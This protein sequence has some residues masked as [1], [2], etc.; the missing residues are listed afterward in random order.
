[1]NSRRACV[2]L[3]TLGK[4]ISRAGY[5]TH[6][7]SSKILA[8]TKPLAVQSHCLQRRFVHTPQVR[9]GLVLQ[10]FTKSLVELPLWLSCHRVRTSLQLASISKTVLGFRCRTPTAW[11]S[12]LSASVPHEDNLRVAA[13]VPVPLQ[14]SVSCSASPWSAFFLPRRATIHIRTQPF[15][16][17]MHRARLGLIP[18]V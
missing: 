12:R 7:K 11:H 13:V 5:K 17:R 3:P 6:K 16:L 1:M 9:S 18:L 15:T 8:S 2:V 4:E 14:I 10:F